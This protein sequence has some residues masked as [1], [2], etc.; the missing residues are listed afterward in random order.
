MACALIENKTEGY[1]GRITSMEEVEE[2]CDMAKEL[3]PGKLK[4]YV[5]LIHSPCIEDYYSIFR[6]VRY[7]DTPERTYDFVFVDGP[8][9][10][11]PSDGM[12]TFDFDYIHVVRKSE[13]PVF[14]IVDKRV[15]SCYVFQK[16]LGPDKVRYSVIYHLGFVGP[17]TKYDLKEI[18][19]REPSSAFSLKF[20]PA[21]N[22]ELRL[23]L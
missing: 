16:L 23:K 12:M 9:Y 10:I 8:K 7:R 19:H 22:T 14:A 3:L 21:G 4:D 18:D 17:C 13:Q 1:R 11:A 5:E 6:G 20:N 15:S 2:Y